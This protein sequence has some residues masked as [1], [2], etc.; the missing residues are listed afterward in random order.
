MSKVQLQGN[1]NGT[2]IFTIA[3]PNS[4]TDRTLTLP[5]NTGTLLS[6]A[7]TIAQNSG[8]AFMAYS[9]DTQ[10]VPHNT[11][12]KLSFPLEE[13]DT[14]SCFILYNLMFSFIMSN[15]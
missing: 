10:S 6:S 12:T 14:G 13:F 9:S 3:S 11:T 8:P 1:V 7:S 15:K 4:N 2:G 5:D